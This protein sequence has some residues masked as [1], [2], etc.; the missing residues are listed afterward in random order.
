MAAA[1]INAAFDHMD[2]GRMDA[3][4]ATF[5][6]AVSSFPESIEARVNYAAC[7]SE[8]GEGQRALK[9]LDTV[10]DT[11]P[12]SFEAHGNAAMIAMDL[13][14]NESAVRHFTAAVA[15]PAGKDWF[16]GHYNLANLLAERGAGFESQASQH[17]CFGRQW[18]RLT[19]VC[20]TH[21]R[22][23]TTRLPLG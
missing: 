7:L 11:H 12:G 22:S 14:D 21:R 18:Y 9:E 13:Q 16:D 19:S 4:K 3:A 20:V 1:L 8:C 5:E 6:K 17:I 23:L 15:L 2:A 10:L